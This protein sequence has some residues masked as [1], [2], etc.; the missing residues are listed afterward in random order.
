MGLGCRALFACLLP[1]AA[2]VM[3]LNDAPGDDQTA[4][5]VL[6]DFDAG[7]EVGYGMYEY[8]MNHAPGK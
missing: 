3:W 2:S 1:F 7:R 5:R 8:R 6:F 4:R